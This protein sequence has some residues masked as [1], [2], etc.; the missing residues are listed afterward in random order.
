M[1]IW[2]W[3]DGRITDIFVIII[4]TKKK[5]SMSVTVWRLFFNFFKME[6]LFDLNFSEGIQKSLQPKN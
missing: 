2:L 1:T 4:L 6:M 3:Q 5:G